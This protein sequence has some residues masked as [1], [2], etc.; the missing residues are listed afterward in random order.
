[1]A[2]HRFTQHLLIL[3]ATT[4][5]F[6]IQ[7]YAQTAED[8]PFYVGANLGAASPDI[9]GFSQN[10]LAGEGNLKSVEDNIGNTVDTGWRLYAGYRINDFLDTEISYSN[11]GT[12][13][14]KASR[15]SSLTRHHPA[16][17]SSQRKRH[18]PDNEQ[19]CKVK[20]R[21]QVTIGDKRSE[22][23]HS[24]ANGHC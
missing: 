24:Y 8:T 16:D 4:L 13:E 3:L 1:M 23:V 11:L 10:D 12:F 2:T 22:S 19:R 21:H 14:R 15:P 9:D 7:T 5:M 17:I 20:T 18:C 6:S